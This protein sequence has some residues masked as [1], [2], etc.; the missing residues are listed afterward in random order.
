M[1]QNIYILPEAAEVADPYFADLL[2][3][4]REAGVLIEAL[5]CSV[6]ENGMSVE[7]EIPVL[8]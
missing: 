3:K 1:L 6:D 4:V 2:L 7:Q 5:R 8:Y